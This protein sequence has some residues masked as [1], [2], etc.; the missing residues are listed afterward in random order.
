MLLLRT[1]IWSIGVNVFIG[2]SHKF[3]RLEKCVQV[4]VFSFVPSYSTNNV[5][6][7]SSDVL[8]KKRNIEPV[9]YFNKYVC[10]MYK[11][12]IHK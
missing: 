6:H 3:N 2:G 5:T 1:K 8:K 12:Y 7:F 4:I 10:L 11:F 9:V